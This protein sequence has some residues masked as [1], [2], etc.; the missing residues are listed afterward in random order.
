[1][2]IEW[3]ISGTAPEWIEDNFQNGGYVYDTYIRKI[4][5]KHYTLHVTYLFRGNSHKYV[6]KILEFAKY[7][8]RSYFIS[9]KVDVV[10]RD[11]FS[12]VFAPF[13]KKHKHVVMLHH[14]DIV[15]RNSAFFYRFFEKRFFKRVQLADMVITVSDYWRQK[16]IE[17][18]CK[19][20]LSI[21]NSF[22]LSLFEFGDQELM[23]FKIKYGFS[24]DKPIIY[25]GNARPEKGFQEVAD[26]LH[27]INAELVVTGRGNIKGNLRLLFLPYND[28]LKL[29]KTSTLIITMSRFTEG[30]NRVAHEA[31]I[32]GTPVIGSGMG[33]MRELLE[34]G[35]QLICS[36][37][38]ELKAMV[39]SLLND[40]L[41]MKQMSI[42]G[43]SFAKQ[44]NLDYFE[45][46]WTDALDSLQSREN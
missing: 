7:I 5:R 17:S 26:V 22:D 21:Y 33:G 16:L 13:K 9:F 24:L 14:L 12:T 8:I 28:Y 29:L 38:G 43:R 25:L 23:S 30:W 18:G 34:K 36:N 37:I 39:Y 2:T 3:L 15:N 41:K 27:G 20:V 11:L 32:C 19:N 46:N 35:G 44:F 40:E 42:A 10:V 6:K 1:L 45:K 31:M 4:L